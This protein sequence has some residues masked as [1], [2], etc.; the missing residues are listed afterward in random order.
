MPRAQ[1]FALHRTKIDANTRASPPRIYL[2]VYSL[3]LTPSETM[4]VTVFK[5]RTVISGRT[6]RKRVTWSQQFL[7]LV[8]FFYCY[9]YCSVLIR[10]RATCCSCAQ[11]CLAVELLTYE[12]TSVWWDT[13]YCIESWRKAKMTADQ[14]DR[15]LEYVGRINTI[16]VLRVPGASWSIA[17]GPPI[18]VDDHW[19]PHHVQSIPI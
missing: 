10:R 14:Q 18:V 12:R 6:L 13:S 7:A 19:H 1:P 5:T 3:S 11:R 15:L 17:A 16:T 9:Y 2:Y 4:W 8:C